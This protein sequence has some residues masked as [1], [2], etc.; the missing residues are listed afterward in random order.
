MMETDMLIRLAMAAK[1]GKPRTATNRKSL[2]CLPAS[3]PAA[4]AISAF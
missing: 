2:A 4:Q 3:W 1:T